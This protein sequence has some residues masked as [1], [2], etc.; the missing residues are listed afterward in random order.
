MHHSVIPKSPLDDDSVNDN[1]SSEGWDVRFPC[2]SLFQ[3]F[4]LLRAR[5][6]FNCGVGQG[7]VVLK[8][9]YI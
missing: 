1:P 4:C 5:S 8:I 6:E 7:G 3:C 9:Y 2:G